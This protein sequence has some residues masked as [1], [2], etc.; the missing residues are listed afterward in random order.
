[1]LQA[2]SYPALACA[3]LGGTPKR[4][5]TAAAKKYVRTSMILSIALLL[6][7]GDRDSQSRC[8]CESADVDWPQGVIFLPHRLP[9][10]GQNLARNYAARRTSSVRV[11]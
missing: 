2:P 7:T 3:A 11:R 10:M 6:L 9:R 5:A 8:K 1:M 4:V